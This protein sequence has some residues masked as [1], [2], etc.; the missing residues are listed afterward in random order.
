MVYIGA[1]LVDHTVV[2]GEGARLTKSETL[3]YVKREV[4]EC[5]EVPL[6]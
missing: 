1:T 4:C 6:G 2:L 3:T 5:L